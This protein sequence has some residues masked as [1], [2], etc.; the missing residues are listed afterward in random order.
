M[1]TLL[2]EKGQLVL[3]GDPRQL[4]PV[5]H[6]GLAREHGLQ[7]SM[8][9]RLMGCAPYAKDQQAHA[10]TLGF[11]PAV[12]TK[13][14]W[15]FRSHPALLA[16]PNSL[17]YDGEL[18]PKANEPARSSCVGWDGLEAPGVPILWEGVEGKDQ[19]EA[20]SPSWFNADEA[21][22][23]LRHVEALLRAPLT[24]PVTAADIGVITPYNKQVAQAPMAGGSRGPKSLLFV[25]GLSVSSEN[26]AHGVRD[27]LRCVKR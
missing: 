6:S 1:G 5:I 12:L 10:E 22:A 25:V 20:H 17:F 24:P 9:E 14:V 19:R 11:E 23:V 7:T 21:V 27:G 8:M 2:G 4:G 13:L 16:L 15:N 18:V 3:A 26:R